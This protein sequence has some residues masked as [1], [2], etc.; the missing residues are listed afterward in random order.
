VT[1][2]IIRHGQSVGNVEP[3]HGDDPPLTPLGREQARLTG[4]RLAHETQV[5]QV[6]AST[7]K[8]AAETAQIIGGIVG[9]EPVLVDWLRE[10]DVTPFAGKT[11]EEI[12]AAW[13]GMWREEL[14]DGW[15]WRTPQG[16]SFRDLYD[17]V[18]AGAEALK[19]DYAGATLA[20]V[21]HG[22][23][24]AFLMGYLL[25]GQEDAFGRFGW[26]NCGVSCLEFRRGRAHLCYHNDRCHLTSSARD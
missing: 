24:G 23:A 13:P 21:S 20:I 25:G 12:E 18:S 7:M 8:R 14:W 1:W 3:G 15:N 22:C 11:L 6:V 17:R 4:Q 10:H 9:A 5:A 19:R 16:E 26:S 2:Y